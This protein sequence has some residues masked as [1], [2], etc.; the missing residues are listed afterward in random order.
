V[1]EEAAGSGSRT[2][3]K[4]LAS[5]KPHAY[6]HRMPDE[7]DGQEVSEPTITLDYQ[8]GDVTNTQNFDPDYLAQILANAL[9]GSVA[10]VDSSIGSDN[11]DGQTAY[12]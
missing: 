11:G 6:A 9:P 1:P 12:A 2:A 10:G 3:P 4:T 5:V 7:S 8:S